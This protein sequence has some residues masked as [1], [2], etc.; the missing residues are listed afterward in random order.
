MN[1]DK[2]VNEALLALDRRKTIECKYLTKI[3][4]NKN[5]IDHKIPMFFCK[6]STIFLMYLGCWKLIEIIWWFFELLFKA[7][8]G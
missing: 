3:E 6:M 7:S 5:N 8:R 2:Q 1:N 4:R